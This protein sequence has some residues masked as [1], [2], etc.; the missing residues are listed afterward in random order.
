MNT[1][2]KGRMPR[3]EFRKSLHLSGP[4][5]KEVMA[6]LE[7]ERDE[8]AVKFL[9]EQRKAKVLKNAE[10][11]GGRD[12]HQDEGIRED[13][14]VVEWITDNK[15]FLLEA[16]RKSADGGNAQSQKL[17]AQMGNLLIEKQE[18]T[19]KIDG[20]FLTREILR[21]RRE[22][23]DSGMVEVSDESPVPPPTVLLSSGQSSDQDD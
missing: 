5:L 9:T 18:V 12:Y 8:K 1:P 4:A 19:H 11:R 22:L 2:F 13:I 16:I 7:L 15:K 20:S 23:Q 10:G 14:D 21:A 17:L 6:E 3:K